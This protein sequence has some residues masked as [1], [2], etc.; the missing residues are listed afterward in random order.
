MISIVKNET[1]SSAADI[2]SVLKEKQ[3]CCVDIKQKSVTVLF[4]SFQYMTLCTRF[5]CFYLSSVKVMSC[6][7]IQIGGPYSIPTVTLSTFSIYTNKQQRQQPLHRFIFPLVFFVLYYV[8][9][10]M[11]CSVHVG[12][13]FRSLPC[14]YQ[15][16]CLLLLCHHVSSIYCHNKLDRG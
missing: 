12:S 4:S 15:C 6:C 11:F 5:V 16:Q 1:Q 10:R 2:L 14:Q 8:K 9:V 3:R 13:E 7:A